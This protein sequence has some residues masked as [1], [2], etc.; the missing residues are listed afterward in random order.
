MIL[1]AA[2][3]LFQMQALS[4]KADAAMPTLPEA[5]TFAENI[6][7]CAPFAEDGIDFL[8]LPENE[9]TKKT[10]KATPVFPDTNAQILSGVY[11][12]EHFEP[13]PH[14]RDKHYDAVR[15]GG[16]RRL[17]LAIGQ[18]SAATFEARTIDRGTEHRKPGS[19]FPGDAPPDPAYLILRSQLDQK[20]VLPR[21]RNPLIPG[22]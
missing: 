14:L 20:P 7:A 17:S 8:N 15:S 9:G 10:P 1:A 18:S 5:V 2:V 11:I 3:M 19:R 16:F 12:P 21:P 4:P 13:L 22:A 6:H